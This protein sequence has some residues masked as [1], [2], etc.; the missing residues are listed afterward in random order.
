MLKTFQSWSTCLTP[1]LLS[2]VR[3]VGQMN[4]IVP[5]GGLGTRFQNQ[6][7]MRPKPSV[8]VLGKVGLQHL[9]FVTLWLA[10]TAGLAQ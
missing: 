1:E 5:L 9:A 6:G 4:V 7:Y 10:L 8:R 3:Q 2:K